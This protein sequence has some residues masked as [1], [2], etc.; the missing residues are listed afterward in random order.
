MTTYSGGRP[1]L[2]GSLGVLGERH[3][4]E[5]E[6]H[7]WESYASLGTQDEVLGEMR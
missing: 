6:S 2:I 3:L 5:W 4:R 7:D 1:A